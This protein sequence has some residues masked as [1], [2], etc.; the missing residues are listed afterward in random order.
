MSSSSR[1]PA[2]S[3][4]PIRWCLAGLMIA[5]TTPAQAYLNRS[6]TSIDESREF[7]GDFFGILK[8][9]KLRILVPRDYTAADYLPR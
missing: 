6:Y 9:G 4:T 1:S 8:Q 7:H 2:T 3:M 5:L